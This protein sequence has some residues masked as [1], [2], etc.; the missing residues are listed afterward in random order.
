MS[1]P[2]GRSRDRGEDAADPWCR[3]V[4]PQIRAARRI[5]DMW[6]EC[7]TR[8]TSRWWSGFKE[9]GSQVREAKRVGVQGRNE[10][11]PTASIHRLGRDGQR[12]AQC[13]VEE[14]EVEWPQ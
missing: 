4:K 9:E 7:A 10:R 8:V 13:G 1:A 5:A 11:S 2:R 6:H 3:A 14:W 12:D